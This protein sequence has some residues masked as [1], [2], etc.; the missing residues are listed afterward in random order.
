[1]L[2]N[3]LLNIG[4]EWLKCVL[5]NKYILIIDGS[6]IPIILLLIFIGIIDDFQ[7]LDK[8]LEALNIWYMLNGRIWLLRV[9]NDFLFLEV[10]E[11]KGR[12]IVIVS[13]ILLNVLDLL[14]EEELILL[15]EL[16]EINLIREI[17]DIMIIQGC[18]H[19]CPIL[20]FLLLEV[21][22]LLCQLLLKLL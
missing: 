4:R 20:I 6:D 10:L 19:S 22:D 11:N 13:D 7:W 14:I 9:V 17:E 15:R 16:I 8:L 18:R 2:P 3:S 21:S 12:A 1:M 5:G